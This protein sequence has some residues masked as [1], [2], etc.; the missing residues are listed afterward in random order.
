[1]AALNPWQRIDRV[2]GGRP[3]GDGADGAYSSATIPT[4]VVDSCSITAGSTTLTTAASTFADGDVI[5]L[6]QTRGTGVGQLEINRVV[7]GGGTATLTLQVASNY[8]FTDSGASQAQVY[9]VYRYTNVTVQAGTWT[10]PGWDGNKNGALVFA[11]MNLTVTGAVNG[12]AAGFAAGASVFPSVSGNQ[13]EGEVGLGTTSTAANGVGGGG[14]NYAS[15]NQRKG[16]GGGGHANTGTTGGVLGTG[17][18]GVGGGTG[19][20]ADLT[21]V[22]FGGAGGSGSGETGTSGGT[23]GGRSGGIF[24]IFC[25]QITVT[26]SMTVDGEAGTSNTDSGAGGGGAGGSGL[27]V[28]NTATLGTNLITAL[29]GSGGDGS[30]GADGGAAS[31]G[32]IAIHHSGTIT[33]STNPTFTDVTDSTLVETGGGQIF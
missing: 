31:E 16:G 15:D 30:A 17:G 24:F 13:G 20:S 28:C 26:G 8:T 19:G 32:R 7:S 11:A 10:I 23:Q 5:L 12:A 2:L 6:H 33:G 21:S 3:Y 4:A 22:I 14:G 27:I 25:K 9:K 18:A 1:M 29:G